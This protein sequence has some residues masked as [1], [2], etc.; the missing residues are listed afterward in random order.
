[1]K[2]KT[3]LELG[4]YK[5]RIEFIDENGGGPGVHLFGKL[6][7][8]VGE[9]EIHLVFRRPFL[10]PGL[11]FRTIA[12]ISIIILALKVRGDR[13]RRMPENPNKPRARPSTKWAAL[14]PFVL[15]FGVV[16]I[17]VLAIALGIGITI[18]A[19]ALR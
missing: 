10:R 8:F 12:K 19:N 16:A 9:I 18:L 1:M 14:E 15:V 2:S 3:S 11:T 4:N 13:D 6:L 5:L 7:L 17:P